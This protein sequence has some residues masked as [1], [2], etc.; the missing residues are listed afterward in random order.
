MQ[1]Y[2]APETEALL[3]ASESDVLERPGASP[4]IAT[5]KASSAATE[6]PK[7]HDESL[8]SSLQRLLAH[9]YGGA[10]RARAN[11]RARTVVKGRQQS[12]AAAE[13]AAYVAGEA[14]M[15]SVD[16]PKGS[17]QGSFNRAHR[18]RGNQQRMNM[19]VDGHSDEKGSNF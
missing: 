15:M 6:A 5:T 7:E 12:E 1:T 11:R 17:F 2:R 4:G 9:G 10:A 19:P 18:R 13:D 3:S 8:S 16:N 14:E